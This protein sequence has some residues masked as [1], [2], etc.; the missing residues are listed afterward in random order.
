MNKNI[1][2][3]TAKKMVIKGK[4][5]LAADESTPTCTK[6]FK[7]IDVESTEHSR[8]EY[9]DMLFTTPNL[10][11]FISGVILYDETFHRSTILDPSISIPS[12]LHSNN[13]LPGIKVDKGVKSLALHNDEVITVGLDDLD[14]RMSEYSNL[15][16]KFAKWRAVI[17]IS[18]KNPSIGCIESN[19]HSLARYA[20]ICQKYNIVHSPRIQTC[21]I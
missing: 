2:N 15:G 20:A 6:R 19:A 3:E 12:F 21:S 16:A 9:R 17:S 10:S 8:N 7:S 14:E 11:D 4:G 13:I 18:D 5:I 1:L